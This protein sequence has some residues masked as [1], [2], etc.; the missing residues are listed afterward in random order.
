M[1]TSLCH[2]LVPH[3]FIW[4]SIFVDLPNFNYDVR[5]SANPRRHRL[6]HCGGFHPQLPIYRPYGANCKP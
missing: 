4:P 1:A 6:A 2:S 3:T 5:L